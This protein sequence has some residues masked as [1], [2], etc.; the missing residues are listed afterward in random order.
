MLDAARACFADAGFA[1][2]TT[3]QIATRAGVVENLI[4]S[5]FGSKAAL[6]DAAVT[7]PFREAITEFIDRCHTIGQDSPQ[8]TARGYVEFLFDMLEGHSELL[9]ALLK[10]PGLDLPLLP[11]LEQLERLGAYIFGANGYSADLQIL[12]R[13]HFGMV[14]FNA[15]FGD[16]LYRADSRPD[17]ERIFTEMAE[18]L[19][20][21]A[22]NRSPRTINNTA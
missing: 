17:R 7:K 20:A 3:R 14:A 11:F 2:T 21:S 8:F 12:I 18:V 5:K 9:F 1:R 22:T 16:M 15:A 4:Y 13:C 10:D 19:I 6:F